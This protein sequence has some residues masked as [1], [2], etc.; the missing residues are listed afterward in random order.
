MIL[1]ARGMF[2]WI[3]LQHRP[4]IIHLNAQIQP[5]QGKADLVRSQA[6]H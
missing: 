2:L 4:L 5:V 6:Y 1:E 3:N